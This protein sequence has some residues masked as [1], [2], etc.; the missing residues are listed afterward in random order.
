ME[1]NENRYT[2]DELPGLIAKLVDH[3]DDLTHQVRELQ[4]ERRASN[5]MDI[6]EL[7]AYLP[8]NLSRHTIYNWIKDDGFPYSKGSRFYVFYRPDVDDWLKG[9]R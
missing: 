5:W 2:F 6:D 8:G 4:K 9:R 1:R 7:I 3:I